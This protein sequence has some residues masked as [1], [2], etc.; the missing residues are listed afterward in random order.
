ME[1]AEVT[2]KSSFNGGA[3]QTFT[4]IAMVDGNQEVSH[5]SSVV[6]KGVDQEHQT[7]VG[8]L[9]PSV[10]YFFNVSAS[11]IH[12]ETLSTNGAS[13]KTRGKQTLYFVNLAWNIYNV[14]YEVMYQSYTRVLACS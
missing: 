5:S 9:Q 7:N 11:N 8:G 14:Q 2:W 3:A 6:D 1:S 13:C 4:A 10:T 12:G